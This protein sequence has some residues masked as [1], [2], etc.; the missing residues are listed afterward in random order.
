MGSSPYILHQNN[1]FNFLN[2]FCIQGNHK[3]PA[4]A[5]QNRPTLTYIH[6]IFLR[7]VQVTVFQHC[8]VQLYMELQCGCFYCFFYSISW[9]SLK[10][11]KKIEFFQPYFY[12]VPFK[13]HILPM[14]DNFKPFFQKTEYSRRSKKRSC[15]MLFFSKLTNFSE[16]SILVL[17]A[18]DLKGYSQVQ[19]L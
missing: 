11:K 2:S 16:M 1:F 13:S 4:F 8:Y 14:F 7:K 6:A 12:F 9:N 5:T 18:Q 15:V 17:V 10:K 3:Q 19:H